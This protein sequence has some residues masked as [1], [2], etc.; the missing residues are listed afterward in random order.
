[1][2]LSI[3]IKRPCMPFT[4]D[5]SEALE[6]QIALHMETVRQAVKSTIGEDGLCALILGGGYGRGEG[7]VYVVDGE[8]RV[9][10][11]YDFFV[12][13]PYTSRRRRKELA[14]ALAQVKAAVE[15]GCGIHVDFSPAMP[16]A[17]LG[18]LPYELMFMELKAGHHVVIGPPDILDALPDYDSA[19]PPMEE[20]ARLTGYARAIKV[21]WHSNCVPSTKSP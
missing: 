21:R 16:L 5:G 7:G 1:M 19:H 4:A 9:Y 3:N 10:N 2:S 20:G 15:P 6:Q 8:E 11:D 14:D 13:V 17:T 12:V 18:G